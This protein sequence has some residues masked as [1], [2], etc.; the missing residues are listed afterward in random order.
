MEQGLVSPMGIID[1]CGI[2]LAIEISLQEGGDILG[3]V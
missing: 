2:F 1:Q 3:K